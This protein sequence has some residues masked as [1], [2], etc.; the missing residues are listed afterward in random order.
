[1]SRTLTV[2]DILITGHRNPL[3]LEYDRMQ[4]GGKAQS[5]KGLSKGTGSNPER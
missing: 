3:Q 4:L 5:G 2:L 1:M